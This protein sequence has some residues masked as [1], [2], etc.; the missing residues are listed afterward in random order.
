M[1]DVPSG[2]SGN[3]GYLIKG[4]DISAGGSDPWGGTTVA[5]SPDIW[6]SV[7]IASIQSVWRGLWTSRIDSERSDRDEERVVTGD[8]GA[9]YGYVLAFGSLVGFYIPDGGS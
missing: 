7:A 9:E 1:I 6:I 8:V 5:V 4:F 2:I 3:G